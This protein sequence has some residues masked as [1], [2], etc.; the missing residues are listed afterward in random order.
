MTP[1]VYNKT[2]FAK[3][4]N[5]SIE[6]VDRYRKLGKLPHHMIGKRVVFT[7]DDLITFLEL[8]A[9]PATNR[10]SK[11]ERHE[12]EKAVIGGENANTA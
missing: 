10:T 1:N 6:T 7:E 12:I 9:I 2:T 8:C 11:R 3:L 5:V 4:L